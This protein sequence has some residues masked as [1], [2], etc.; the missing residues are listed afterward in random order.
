M[1]GNMKNNRKIGFKKL[2]IGFF[3][4]LS[5]TL[6]SA[7]FSSITINE[8]S[9]INRHISNDIYPFM[10]KLGEFE[11]IVL[12]SK[13]LSTNWVYLQYNTEDKEELKK[14]INE[15]YPRI[16]QEILASYIAAGRIE[17]RDT[18]KL[19]FNKMDNLLAEESELIKTLITFADYENA[20]KLF[21][22]EEIIESRVIPQSAEIKNLLNHFILRTKKGND[23]I[24][25][26]MLYSFKKLEIT[27]V[28]FGFGMFVIIFLSVV[29]LQRKI[30]SPIIQVRNILLRL[31]NGEIITEKVKHTDDVISQMVDALHKLSDNFN[32]TAT[33]A[34]KIGR[35]DF[36]IKVQPLSEH[37]ILGSA[38]LEMRNNLKAYS[39]EMEEK[40]RVRTLEI[41]QQKEIIEERNKDITA[42]INYAKRIQRASL[43]NIHTIQSELQNSFILFKPKDI[44]SGD[45]Y[46]YSKLGDKII[47][48]AI[49]CTGH[50][51][52]GAFMSLIGMNILSS[53]VNESKITESNLI[54][55]E[56]HKRIQISLRQSET[57]NNDG[58]D[59]ALCVID[60]NNNTLE[61]SGAHNPLIYICNDDLYAIKG[62]KKGIGGIY[63]YQE[64]FSKHTIK[65]ESPMSFYIFSD[66]YQDQFGGEK[67]RKFMIKN[68]K[69]MFIDNSNLSMAEQKQIYEQTMQK[70]LKPTHQVD[71]ILLIGFNLN[72][73]N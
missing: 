24:R 56:M 11:Q 62:D 73:N 31:S 70:W 45:F 42:S 16:K 58:M 34:Y 18:L 2:V 32:K 29:Y 51:V 49:D 22:G 54:L 10:D 4:V 5:I 67:D 19:I 65:I 48:A 14:L 15:D 72:T 66:G 12:N 46:W 30:T 23:N 71:D 39:E 25:E 57:E 35:G 1:I 3:V 53:I 68:M 41:S 38:I 36:N 59:V 50:G 69:Q 27:S 60:K 6:F 52:P 33:A 28:F 61:F 44:V 43:P 55:E 20:E 17:E 7:I 64:K 47:I 40:V 8:N 37:D 21:G 26:K 13:M 9:K 63:N